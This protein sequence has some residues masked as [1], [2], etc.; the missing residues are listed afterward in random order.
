M[1]F[2]TSKGELNRFPFEQVIEINLSSMVPQ[3]SGPKRPQDRVAVSGMKED[4]QSC[5]DEK[6]LTTPIITARL[7]L[8]APIQQAVSSQVGFKGF[9]IAKEKQDVG[10]PFLHCG[11]EYKLTHGSVVI[12]AVISCTNNCNPSAMLTAGARPWFLS[13][14]FPVTEPMFVLRHDPTVL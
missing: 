12:A 7:P 14:L 1:F 10:I 3:V 9:H 2:L 11:R 4:F 5:L 8:R 13:S 6:V